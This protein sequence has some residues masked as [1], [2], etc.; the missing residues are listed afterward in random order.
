MIRPLVMACGVI[1]ELCPRTAPSPIV[2]SE[3]W[4]F[5]PYGDIAPTFAPKSIATA[6][7][8]KTVATE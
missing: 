1:T 8:A 3:G 5:S 4:R 6:G 2:T 7:C